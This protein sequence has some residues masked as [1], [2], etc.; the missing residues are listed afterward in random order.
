MKRNIVSIL[1]INFILFVFCSTGLAWIGKVVGISD[2]DT[3]TVLTEDKQQIKIRL[4]GVDCPEGH[5]DFGSRAKQFTSDKVFGKMVDIET[6]SMDKY[7]RTIAMVKVNGQNLSQLLIDNGM[8]WVY[9]RY[10]H[11]PVCDSWTKSQGKAKASKNGLWSMSN[12]VPPWDYRHN[13]NP[14][15]YAEDAS[16]NHSYNPPRSYDSSDSYRPST[17]YGSS[18]SSA[19]QGVWVRPYTRK[20]GT[21]VKGHYRS[22]PGR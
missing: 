4:Y 19:S 5:Q 12:P 7:G 11:M 9:D 3:I 17:S 1:A 6:F 16:L 8:A 18:S 15:I 2:G 10:C 14:G 20:D 13:G 22:A 21:E